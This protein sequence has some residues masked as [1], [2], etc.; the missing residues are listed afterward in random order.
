VVLLVYMV[1]RRLRVPGALLAAAIFAVHPVHA[2]SVA[3][4]SEQKN[5]LSAVFYL[6]AMLAYLK[7]GTRKDEGRITNRDFGENKYYW[8]S[9]S[10]FVLG[11]FTKTVTATLPAALLVVF[12]WQRGTLSGRDVRPLVLLFLAGAAAGALT[13]W[14]ERKLI[15]AEGAQFDLSLVERAL[16]AGRAIWFYVG[17]LIWPADLVF[18]YPRW[19]VDPAVWWQWLFPLFALAVTAALALASARWRGP[20]ACWLF[21]VGTLFPVLGFLNVYPFIYSFVADHFQYLASLGLIVLFAAGAMRLAPKFGERAALAAGAVLVVTLAALTWRQSAMYADLDVLY[22]TTIERNP[23]CWMA[24]NNLGVHAAKD[25]LDDAAAISFFHRAIDLKPDY[26][27]THYNLANALARLGRH[28]EALA[29]F[30]RAIELKPTFAEAENNLA[31]YLKSSGDLNEALAHFERAAKL[32]PDDAEIQANL[33]TA[34]LVAGDFERAADQARAAIRLEPS[35]AEWHENLGVALARGG[36]LPEAARA[37]QETIRLDPGHAEALS[38]LAKAFAALG[39]RTEAIATAKA[40]LDLAKSNGDVAA[41][42]DI[43]A[44]LKQFQAEP[45]KPKPAETPPTTK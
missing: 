42:T 26:A 43:E 12:W 21:F 31:N 14:V 18:I 9:F 16:I 39:K 8:L 17:K 45:S 2:E 19:D 24:Y 11:L 35:H 13:A 33:G 23:A 20:L 41:G 6:G 34:Y 37:F 1:L 3:W 5:T 10:L 15:G 36:K 30:E 7:G 4:I 38:N 28:K 27:D 44:W 29:E 22:Q 25:R 32:A 40:A